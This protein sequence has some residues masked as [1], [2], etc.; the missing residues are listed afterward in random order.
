[1]SRP[2]PATRLSATRRLPRWPTTSSASSRTGRSRRGGGARG[3]RHGAG[4]AATRCRPVCW[5]GSWWRALRASPGGPGSGAPPEKLK[6]GA[7]AA[8]DEARQSRNDAARQAAGLWLDRGIE[9]ARGGEPAR[10]LHLFVRALGAIP[11]DDPEAA[12]LERAIRANLAAWAETV[13]AL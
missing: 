4:V 5:W 9:D 8:R 13:P 6:K 3:R 11:A 2:S 10:A 7:E 1:S 12:P